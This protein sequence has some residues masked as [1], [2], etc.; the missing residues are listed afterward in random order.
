[1]RRQSAK[2]GFYR[3]DPDGSIVALELDDLDMEI[4]DLRLQKI[5]LTT[6]GF[7]QSTKKLEFYATER[8]GDLSLPT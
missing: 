2:Q 7:N 6:N 5:A 3:Q 4:K 1:M 8:K